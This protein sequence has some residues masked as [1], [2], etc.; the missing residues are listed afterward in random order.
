L[1][2]LGEYAKAITVEAGF[3]N[4]ELKESSKEEAVDAV[5]CSLA[6]YFSAGGDLEHLV[7]YGNKK[8]KKWKKR[9]K[10]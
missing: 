4:K 1:Q 8:L 7:E 2:E 3:K 10:V 6:L 9:L 5:I